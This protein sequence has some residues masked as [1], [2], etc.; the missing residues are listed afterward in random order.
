MNEGPEP[1]ARRR[2]A[3][4]VVDWHQAAELLAQGMSIADAATRVGCSRGA[5]A[6]RRKHDAVFQTW[7]ARCRE[8]GAE[9]DPGRLVDLRPT[10]Q[11]SIEEEVR[12]GNVRVILWLSDRLKLVTP[13]SERTPDQELRQILD[14]LTSEEL[15]EFEGL[16]DA[17]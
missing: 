9:P 11:E 13:P 6:R 16:R 14:G 15:C 12:R 8:A 4:R 10:L 2:T 5:L 3:S 7:M 1:R 17:P